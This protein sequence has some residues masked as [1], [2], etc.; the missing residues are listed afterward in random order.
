MNCEEMSPLLGAYLDGELDL[1]TS[2]QAEA[3]VAECAA[4]QAALEKLTALNA[5]LTE[6]APRYAAPEG[7]RARVRTIMKQESGNEIQEPVKGP[8][9]AAMSADA[10]AALQKSGHIPRIRQDS[11]QVDALKNRRDFPQDLFA[12]TDDDFSNSSSPT[13]YQ[14]GNRRPVSFWPLALAAAI[15]A[16][17]FLGPRVQMPRVS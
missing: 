3:H 8:L 10:W 9:P 1:V 4:C 7:L 6:N 12:A 17:I 5:A 15:L 16:A 2:M 13:L 11:T 14:V